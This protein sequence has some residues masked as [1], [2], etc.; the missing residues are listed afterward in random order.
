MNPHV[1]DYF[2]KPV[3]ITVPCE[4]G[5]DLLSPAVAAPPGSLQDCWNYEVT[6][7]S[8]YTL[9]SGLMLFAGKGFNVIREWIILPITDG[10]ALSDFY[11]GGTYV[12]RSSQTRQLA[13][14]RLL[15]KEVDKIYLQVI[16]GDWKL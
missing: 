13:R 5:L 12:I 4:G 6:V 3:A 10:D 15:K 1:A 16:D 11:E 2:P 9:S 14:V 8:G 7:T